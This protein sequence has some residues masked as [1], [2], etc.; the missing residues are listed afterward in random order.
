MESFVSV[1]VNYGSSVTWGGGAN[2]IMLP[3]MQYLWREHHGGD[4]GGIT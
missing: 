4:S 3:S 2:T 1:E